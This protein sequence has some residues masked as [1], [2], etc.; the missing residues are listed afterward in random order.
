MANI[1]PNQF[2]LVSENGVTKVEYETSSFIGQPS[3]NLTQGS[4][5]TR[6]FSGSQ[7]RTRR[8]EI[9]TL[10]TVTINVTVDTG[11]TSLSVLIPA[12]SLSSVS[13]HETFSTEAIVTSHTGPHSFPR[14][15]VHETYEFIPMKG[16]AS[17]LVFFFESV[18]GALAKSAKP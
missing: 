4:G 9:G 11:S 7:I 18:M 10:V 12:I 6:H 13:D 1:Q 2:A 16:E 15:G 5:P 17:F 8:T 14:A 3:L